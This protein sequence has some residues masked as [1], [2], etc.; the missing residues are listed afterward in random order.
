MSGT[1]QLVWVF[2]RKNSN[3]TCA[4]IPLKNG[5]FVTLSRAEIAKERPQPRDGEIAK[6]YFPLQSFEKPTQLRPYIQ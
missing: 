1:N 2:S 6:G 4:C 3:G 5:D